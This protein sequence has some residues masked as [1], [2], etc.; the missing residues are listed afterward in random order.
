MIDLSKEQR[1]YVT[2]PSKGK[3]SIV[4][5]ILAILVG[6]ALTGSGT[7][8]GWFVVIIGLLLTLI[9]SFSHWFSN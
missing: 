4:L 3:G 1:T 6:F 5:G 9:G 7:G 2:N 8:A